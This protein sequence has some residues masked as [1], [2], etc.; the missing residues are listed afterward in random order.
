MAVWILYIMKSL[1]DQMCKSLCTAM[2]FSVLVGWL[3]GRQ[4][5]QPA[6][7]NAAEAPM[8]LRASKIC[9]SRNHYP[10]TIFLAAKRIYKRTVIISQLCYFSF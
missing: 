8:A 7:Q 2:W 1:D 6:H 4:T 10:V 9:R 3:G 5:I